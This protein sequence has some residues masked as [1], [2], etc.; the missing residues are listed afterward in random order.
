MENKQIVKPGRV[1]SYA[2]AFMAFLIGSGFA[3]G[4]EVLQYFASYGLGG[5]LLVA[6]ICVV[7]FIFVG[8]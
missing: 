8:G 3:T 6:L 2:G 4:Q 1:L 7:L 5:G